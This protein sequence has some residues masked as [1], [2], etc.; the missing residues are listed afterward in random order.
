MEKITTEITLNAELEEVWNQY[1]NPESIKGWAFA[2]ET[3]ECPYAENDLRA[4]G[5]F[6]TRMQAKDKSFGFD[7]TGIYTEVDHLQKISYTMDKA[8][9]EEI[10]REC[11]ITFKALGEN[12]TQVVVVFD[13]ENQNPI[14]MQ[15]AGWQA[16]LENFKKYV[17]THKIRK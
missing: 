2:S 14:E 10:G 16:I 5:R 8:P 4:G 9:D 17:E 13:S 15:K 11:E 6:V 7:F 1:T 12:T 3:W